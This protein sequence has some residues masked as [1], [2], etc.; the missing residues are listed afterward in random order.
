MNYTWGN[1]LNT[2]FILMLCMVLV[3]TL[4]TKL[5]LI[6]GQQDRADERYE[7][8]YYSNH[9]L[10]DELNDAKLEIQRLQHELSML[11]D[12][13]NHEDHM[14]RMDVE[15]IETDVRVLQQTQ[16]RAERRDENCRVEQSG[17]SIGS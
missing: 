3:V 13:V 5:S 8:G 12:H 10:R 9:E 4:P 17:S 15:F 14:T 11:E 6:E 2:F 16:D 1:F 7:E